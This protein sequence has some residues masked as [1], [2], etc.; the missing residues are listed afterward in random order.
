[1]YILILVF[2][3]IHINASMYIFLFTTFIRSNLLL[4]F[5][6]LY[7]TNSYYNDNNDNMIMI[8]NN[9]NRLIYTNHTQLKYKNKN[10]KNVKI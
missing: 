5:L 1:M 6:L 2:I 8:S 7:S 10:V 4:T 3:L 9:D